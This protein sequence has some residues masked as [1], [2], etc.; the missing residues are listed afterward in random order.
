MKKLIENIRCLEELENKFNESIKELKEIF[1]KIE[2][3]KE[4]IKLEIQKIFTKIRNAINDR[5]DELLLKIGYIFNAKYL[6]EDKIKK[7]ENLP[8]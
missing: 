3:Y 8:K 6:N 7:G 1:E 5:E 4:N 2:K